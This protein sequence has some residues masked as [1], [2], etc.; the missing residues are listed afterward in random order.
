MASFGGLTLGC[1]YRGCVSG[2][3]VVNMQ[4]EIGQE[5]NG[6]YRWDAIDGWED[7]E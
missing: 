7:L 4:N 6:E 1:L 3:Q 5:F 2:E